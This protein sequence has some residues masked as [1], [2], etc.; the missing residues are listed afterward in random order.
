MLSDFQ[1]SYLQDILGWLLPFAV[2]NQTKE[3][4]ATCFFI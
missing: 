4:F 3:N 1:N 2:S